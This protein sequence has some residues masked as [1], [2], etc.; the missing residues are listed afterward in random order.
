MLDLA[1]GCRIGPW[2]NRRT[3]LLVGQ[4]LSAFAAQFVQTRSDRHEII[5]GAGSGHVSSVLFVV[6]GCP[7]DSR[8]APDRYGL[9]VEME[10]GKLS[11]LLRR[12]NHDNDFIGPGCVRD[13]G[14]DDVE[15]GER[16]ERQIVLLLR[17][18][19]HRPLKGSRRGT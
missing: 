8:Y 18:L 15:I 10:S 3:S 19:L 11:C 17:R 12:S 1:S 9:T 14:R 13:R 16:G 5:G 6:T 7:H 2:A 4:Y